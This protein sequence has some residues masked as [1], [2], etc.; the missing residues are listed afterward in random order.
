MSYQKYRGLRIDGKGFAYGFLFMTTINN[1]TGKHLK[2][3][4]QEIEEN[5]VYY[6]SYEIEPSTISML[7]HVEKN[8][9]EWYE[10]DIAKM[11][12]SVP[13]TVR[14]DGYGY[15]NDDDGFEGYAIGEVCFNIRHGL[16]LKNYK[17]YDL[18]SEKEVE[19]KTNYKTI[20]LS[21]TEIIGN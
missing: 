19:K 3:C 15:L 21:R 20:V 17:L 8:G 18:D 12:I 11:T 9:R 14:H 13:P 7:I 4:I 1:A 5:G 10:G 16:C 6:N 2:P